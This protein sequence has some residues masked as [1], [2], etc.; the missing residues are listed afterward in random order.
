MFYIP[1]KV[2]KMKGGIT[3][4]KGTYALKLP[5]KIYAQ[6]YRKTHTKKTKFSNSIDYRIDE[7]SC[8]FLLLLLIFAV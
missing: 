8:Y 4:F 6:F 2:H 3:F 1:T 7:V 5:N